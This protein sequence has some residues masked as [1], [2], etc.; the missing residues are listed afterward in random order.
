LWQRLNGTSVAFLRAPSVLFCALSV[1][2]VFSLAKRIAGIAA[3]VLAAFFLAMNPE[4][5]DAA[6][7]MR[8]YSL[9]ILCSAS[10]AWFAHA[11]LARARS[12]THLLGFA[13][14]LVFAVYTH[15]FAWLMATSFLL[16]F[17]WDLYRSWWDEAVRRRGLRYLA[18]TALILLP[19]L[20]HGV[21]ASELVRSRHSLYSGVSAVPATFLTTIARTLFLGELEATVPAGNYFLLAPLTLLALGIV[22]L[23][24]R[25]TAIAAAMFLPALFGAWFLSRTS[26]V[27]ARYLCFLTPAIAIFMGV[28]VRM[29][30]AEY[31]APLVVTVFWLFYFATERAYRGPPID[32]YDVGARLDQIR[33]RGDVVA[34]F[35]G[36]FV[37]TLR[38]YSAV[39]D[40]V[41]ITFPSDLQRLLTRRRHVLFVVNS[42]RYFGN[43][44]ALLDKRT[45]WT[46]L[47]ESSSPGALRVL[48]VTANRQEATAAIGSDPNSILFAGVIGSGGFPWQ[49]ANK[50]RPLARLAKLF[51]GSRFVLADYEAYHPDWLARFLIGAEQ[52]RQLVPGPM[53][54]SMLQRSD[55]SAIFTN[56]VN[57]DCAADASVLSATGLRLI[58][59]EAGHAASKVEVFQLRR[60]TV[61]VFTIALAAIGESAHV[62]PV[63]VE[64]TLRRARA[65]VGDKGRLIAVFRAPADYSRLPTSFERH[66][67]RRLIDAGVDVVLGEGGYAAKEVEAYSRGVIAYSLGT[68]LRPPLL[69]LAM[70]DSTG[71][72]LRLSFPEGGPP[73]YVVVPLTFDDTAQAALAD[74]GTA[75]ERELSPEAAGVSLVDQLASAQVSYLLP[76]G[77]SRRLEGFQV[78]ATCLRPWEE[79]LYKRASVVTQWFPEAP[80]MTPLRPFADCFCNANAYVAERGVL[81]LGEY[82]HAVEIHGLDTTSVKLRFPRVRLGDKLELTYGI[83]DDRLLSKFLPLHDE[84]ITFAVGTATPIVET[85]PYRAGWN[86]ASVDTSSVRGSADNIDITLQANGTHFPVAVD[87][88]VS[89]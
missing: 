18:G 41:P 81:S 28:A 54:V 12:R 51:A 72:A 8:L 30:K 39:E 52:A 29:P 16:L 60:V 44:E 83:P 58:P 19:Q 23:R 65:A 9:L 74:A 55:I 6:R 64:A 22:S 43:V 76:G 80:T 40:L 67:A 20:A 78:R 37:P 69:S 89:P 84:T 77:E 34:V 53:S 26:Q 50:P 24:G 4:V 88:R 61:G 31:F 3:G 48:S 68:L 46:S 47:F 57:Q 56:C 35:P 14:S 42:G 17:G 10:C 86:R 15:L 1:A 33:T 2:I 25:G 73:H 32:W 38:R 11:Y 62:L 7:S 85:I 5:V 66:A 79:R 45:R 75:T 13:A 70:R 82:R 27:E 49:S 87:L 63:Q 71:I 21:V 36:Y 59:K